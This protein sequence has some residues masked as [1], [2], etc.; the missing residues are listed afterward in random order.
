[1]AAGAFRLPGGGDGGDDIRDLL[2]G[3]KG[4]LLGDLERLGTG[5]NVPPLY[6]LANSTV[7]N[8]VY[9]YGAA[10]TFPTGSF[11]ATNYWVDVLF[12]A[13]S[14]VVPLA[15][16][17]VTATSGVGSATV[18][19]QRREMVG[20][21]SPIHGD[22][23]R[24]LRRP[25]GDGRDRIAARHV[26]DGQ[27][28]DQWRDLHL[29]GGGHQRRGGR[30]GLAPSNPATPQAS[31]PTC[32]C[33]ILGTATP[34]TVDS[35]DGNSVNLGVQFTSDTNGFID[36]IRFYKAATNTGIHVGSLWGPDGTLL[37][38]A[39]FAGETASGWQQVLFSSPVP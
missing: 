15:P 8:G 21:R 22:A 3:A 24:R 12:S 31:P 5:V 28:A 32:P 2:S 36:G 6:A 37:A 14:T 10:S 9:A 30:S 19:G 7:A 33:S 18:R 29:H 11:N 38:T 34:A 35:G 39:T 4:S 20:A 26:D 16:T 27:R 13:T 25:D 23:V 1:M 17:V